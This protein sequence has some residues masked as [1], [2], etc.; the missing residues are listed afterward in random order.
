MKCRGVIAIMLLWLWVSAA[1]ASEP[2]T[3]LK[4]DEIKAEPFRDAKKVGALVAGD[5]VEI[6]KKDG[7]W[8]Q[9]KSAKGNGWVHMLSIRRGEARKSGADASGLLGLASGRA[10]TGKVVATTGVRGLNEEDLKTAKFNEGQVK[11][12]ESFSVGK[13]AAAKFAAQGKL[14]ARKLDYLPAPGQ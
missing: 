12:L 10:G 1:I 14:K 5:R 13:T 9:V 8:F 7:G 11:K 2:G 4:A 3:A 6:L